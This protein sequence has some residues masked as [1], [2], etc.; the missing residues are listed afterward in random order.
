[1]GSA[2][3]D[4]TLP[5]GSNASTTAHA[6]SAGPRHLPHASRTEMIRAMAML[7]RGD[8]AALQQ[9]DWLPGHG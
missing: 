2:P 9:L 8:L 6:P 4:R 5:T 3:D 7:T 1:M